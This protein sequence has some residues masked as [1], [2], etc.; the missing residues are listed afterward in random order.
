MAFA[1]LSLLVL[2]GALAAIPLILHLTMRRRP[3]SITFPAVRF[4]VQKRETNQRSLN[5]RHWILLALRILV[6]ALLALAFARPSVASAVFGDWVLAGALGIGALLMAALLI[7]AVVQN[8]GAMLITVFTIVLLLLVGGG[9]HR[10]V[11]ALQ[12]GPKMLLGDGLAP[13]SAVFVFDDSPRMLLK[14]EN[15][16]RLQAAQTLASQLLGQLPPDSEAAI[17][18]TRAQDATNRNR[19]MAGFVPDLALASRQVNSIECRPANASIID[20]VKE[21]L[22]LLKDAKKPRKEVYI[23]TDLSAPSWPV[24]S[25]SMLREEADKGDQ[26][27]FF[28]IDVGLEKPT[29]FALENLTLSSDTPA[30]NSDLS[31]EVDIRNQGGPSKRQLR[32]EIEELDPRRWPILKDGKMVAPPS[33][34]RGRQAI[35]LPENGARQARFQLVGVPAGVYHGRI[36]LDQPDAL[37]VDDEVTFTFQSRPMDSFLIVA[38]P[39]VAASLL[40]DAVSLRY[41]GAIVTPDKIDSLDLNAFSAICVLDPTPMPEISWKK[42]ESFVQSGGGLAIFLGHHAEGNEA[43]IDARFASVTA[44]K[45]LPAM[46]TRVARA[47]SD[48][49]A[50]P[51][52]YEHPILRPL[53]SVSTSVPWERLPIFYYWLLG[54]PASESS[55]ILRTSSGEPLYLERR[56]AGEDGKTGLVLLMATPISDPLSPKGRPAWNEIP[57]G[58][59]AWPFV[60]LANESL[61][62]LCSARRDKLNFTPGSLVS[63]LND[64]RVY[65][66]RYQLFTP[67]GAASELVSRDGLLTISTTNE[68]GIFRLKG[69]RG[70]PQTRGFS[71]R[72]PAGATD[73]TRIPAAQLEEAF[74]KDRF[75]VARNLSEIEHSLTSARRGRDF[76]PMIIS[77][78][79]IVFALE[80]LLANRFYKGATR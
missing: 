33:A 3:K 52:S 17:L 28:V 27:G 10:V 32:L 20:L 77:L 40:D 9:L 51:V 6:L 23:F 78:L 11:L 50:S 45:L 19:V 41:I 8:R 64:E 24:D 76:Y 2:G 61:D 65:P 70:G 62:Y 35:D 55:V 43:K 30:A 68:L 59:D 73:L 80:N 67:R 79:A 53:R 7:G 37:T 46:P 54:P 16:T 25:I 38:P 57:T 47:A 71:V 21:A 44:E 4:L 15:K 5:L 49:F 56:I 31:V 66:D 1:H 74:G 22:L 13:V 69:S 39:D 48:L 34:I 60:V 58:E 63:L 18:S 12:K 14:A 42:L 29:N 36:L 26:V 72:L 75:Q